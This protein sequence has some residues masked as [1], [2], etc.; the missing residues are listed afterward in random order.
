ME[1][2]HLM[3]RLRPI[4]GLKNWDYC[5][6]WKL[7]E[8]Q[9]FLEWICCCCGGAE[10]NMHSCEQELLFPDS[11]TSPCR[12]VMFQH[13]RTTACDLLA[14]LPSSLALDSGIY[15][16]ALLSNQAKWVNFVPFSESNVSNEIIG[17]K[18]LIPSP[19]GLL[20]LFGAKQLPED[21]KVIDFVSTQCNI[22]LEQHKFPSNGDDNTN[23]QNLYQQIVSPV[24]SRDHS[25]QLSYDFPLKRKNLDT[26]SMNFL[27]HFNTYNTSEIENNTTTMLFDQ[28]TSDVTHFSTSMENKY[29]SEMDAY[30]QKQMMRNSSNQTGLIDDESVKQH[31]NGRSNSGSDSDQ[32][33]D[34]DDPKF[35]RRNG[36]GQSKNLVAER[37][38]RKKLNERL[39]ALRALVPKI[40]KLD[41]ASILGDAIEYVMELEKQVKDLQLELE[42]HS[43]DDQG[44][45]NQNQVQPEVLGQNGSDQN[46]RPKSENVKLSNGSHTGISANSNGS[47]DPSR[48]NQEVEDNDKLQQMEPQVEVAQLDGNEFFV[49]VFREH[50]AGGF[51]RILEA[52]NSLGLAVTNVNA[53]RHT[54]LVSSIFKVEKRD[55]E[56]VQADHV[57]ESLLELTRNPSKGWSEMGRPS[58]ENNANGSTNYLHNNQHQHHLEN[59]HQKQAANSHHFHRH[60]HM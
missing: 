9:R 22:Y 49:K 55:N 5:V 56:M 38:R 14:Q 26:S 30:L 15:A 19:L 42:E 20:E 45:R 57:R 54:C 60:H 32:N 35:R 43:D 39:Y 16:Q 46:N 3:E 25:D 33:E 48:Q 6:L 27:P 17:T 52:L 13:P 28:N 21:E 18:V 4:M 50:K 40:S 23:S 11:S 37:K 44:G 51:V 10:Q 7:S 36:K 12:D 34:E 1:L 59:N 29:M 8:D 2:M 24:T 53:T 58:S 31:D 41:R 47:I